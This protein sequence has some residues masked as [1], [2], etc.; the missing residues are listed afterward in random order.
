ML[1]RRDLIM[2]WSAYA[3]AALALSFLFALLLRDAE[4]LGVRMFLPPV[5]VAVVASL[6]DA[7]FA[8]AFGLIC[9]LLCDLTAAGAF[10]CLYTLA[11]TLAGLAGAALAGRV[12]QQG[13]LCAVAVTVLTFAV[14]DALNML[15]FFFKARAPFGAMVSLALRETLVSCLLLAA[16]YPV[17]RRLHGRFSL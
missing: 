3:L 5:L 6:E 14:V 10:P 13:L 15:A 1:T 11:F 17:M 16:V 9:G 7:R 8:A 2:K 4:V 12:L